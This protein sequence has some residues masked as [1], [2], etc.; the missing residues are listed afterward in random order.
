MIIELFKKEKDIFNYSALG[1]C[2]PDIMWNREEFDMTEKERHDGIS[3]PSRVN[4]ITNDFFVK[5]EFQ[6]FGFGLYFVR[7]SGY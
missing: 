1:L 2:L 7:Q 5:Y 3:F 6:I 4:R